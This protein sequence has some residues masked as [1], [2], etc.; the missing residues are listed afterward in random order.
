MAENE[1][2]DNK[3]IVYISG[4]MFSPADLWFQEKIATTLQDTGYRTYLPQRDGVEVGAVMGLI[5]KPIIRDIAALVFT[6][7]VEFTLQATFA[8]DVYNVLKRCGALVFNMDGRVPDGGSVVEASLA[9]TAGRPLVIYKNTPISELGGFDNPMIT[10]LSSTW[11]YVDDLAK[12]PDALAAAIANTKPSPYEG[13]AIPPHLRNVIAYGEKVSVVV[14][15]IHEI[16][17]SK[18][19]DTL[20]KLFG[21]LKKRLMDS[22]EYH[23]AFKVKHDA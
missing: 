5:K 1:R 14:D 7:I 23:A 2:H 20:A 19:D 21:E 4:P 16:Q 12:V 22:P 15:L 3:P 17:N 10:G 13:D 6:D 8:L 18:H 11:K 9:F